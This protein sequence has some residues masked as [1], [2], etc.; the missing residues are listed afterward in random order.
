M[1]GPVYR[2]APLPA[3]WPGKPTLSRKAGPFAENWTSTMEILQRE[4]R[5]LNA[6]EVMLQMDVR[7]EDLRRDGMVSASARPGPSVILVFTSGANRL[8]FPCD[9]FNWWQTNVRAI[10]LALE[11]LRKV[12]RYGVQAGRQYEGFKAL[13]SGGS[14]SAPAPMGPEEAAKILAQHSELP[15]AVIEHDLQTLR[16]AARLAR[17]KAH[18]DKGGT[19]VEFQRVEEAIRILES[20]LAPAKP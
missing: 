9:R 10:A 13:G 17:A 7:V 15:A 14:S 8:S 4:L 20:S 1:S 19:D 2:V 16:V 12:D 3:K 5:M 18:P 11:A 6:R